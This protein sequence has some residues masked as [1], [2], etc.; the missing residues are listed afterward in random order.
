M[1][2][3]SRAAPSTVAVPASP[4]IAVEPESLA[5]T[6]ELRESPTAT[7]IPLEICVADRTASV[8]RCTAAIDITSPEETSGFAGVMVTSEVCHHS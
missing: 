5:T 2:S 7:P 8:R 1:G 3:A 4:L 6:S